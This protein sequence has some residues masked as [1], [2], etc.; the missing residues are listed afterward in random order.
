[1]AIAIALVLV[2]VGC[3]SP[4]PPPGVPVPALTVEVPG[5]G[6][7]P[8]PVAGTVTVS[9]TASNFGPTA[10]ELWIDA[11][12]GAPV[13]SDATA[14]FRLTFSSASLSDGSHSLWVRGV[15]GGYTVL[16]AVGVQVDNRVYDWTTVDATLA[17]RPAAVGVPGVALHVARHGSVV[18]QK[19][20]GTYTADTVVRLASGS[21]WLSAAAIMTLVDDGS[22]DLDAPI[23]AYLPVFTGPKAAITLRQLLSFTSGLQE[24]PT[25]AGRATVT[26]QQCAAEI[27]VLPLAA[28]PGAQYRYGNGHLVV[29][30]AI[31]E[32]VSGTPFTTLFWDRLSVPLGAPSTVMTGGANPNPA[33]NARSTMRD[34]ARFVRMLWNG[35]EIDGTRILSAD[36]VA[37]MQQDQTNGA[38]IVVASGIRKALGSRYGLGSWYD[39]LDPATGAYEV[40]SPG[41]FGFHPWIDRER[42]V[43]GV[44]VIEAPNEVS[45]GGWDVKQQVRVA[46]DGSAP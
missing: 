14:P 13:A 21:K 35:G 46:I 28:Q 8:R 15:G 33:G 20:F 11:I 38:P 23:S 42:D 39:V 1:V 3:V 27:A 22:L 36:A 26:L 44:Y 16:D 10:V 37:E 9:V 34:Y 12:K 17:A 4:T 45:A 19:A 32:S 29:A 2:A 31:A 40:S 7:A 18:Y 24:E 30:A 6:S 5:H 25:C 41:A 43:Y